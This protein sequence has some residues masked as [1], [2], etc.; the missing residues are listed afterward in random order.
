MPKLSLFVTT[1]NNDDTLD[2]CLASVP[3]A[4]EVVVVDSFSTDNTLNIAKAHGAHLFQHRFMGYGPQKQ[5]A[6]DKTTNDWVLLLD[7]DEVL[8]PE[9]A[10]EIR[11]V[12]QAEPNVTGF[13]IGRQEQIFWQMTHRNVRLNHYLRL[14]NKQFGGLDDMPI[15]AAPKV[16]GEVGRLQHPFLHFGEQDIH[17][18][19]E[20]INSYSTGLVMEKASKG[21]KSNGLLMV[22]YPL[23]AF[24]RSYVIKRRFLDGWAGFI[25]SVVMA[26][27][28]FLKYAKLHEYDVHRQIGEARLPPA[29]RGRSKHVPKGQ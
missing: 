18:K 20:K 12:L 24:F 14:F 16:R 29:A 9:C 21:R 4:D 7:A 2:A 8:S 17:T 27:Y 1:F 19:V 11:S 26:F 5:L 25:G 3:F 28:T 6:L 13:T 15:H 23:L 22:L 10:E